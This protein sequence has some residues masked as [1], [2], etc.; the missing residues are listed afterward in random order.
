MQR[1]LYQFN[2]RQ[3]AMIEAYYWVKLFRFGSI[4]N[5]YMKDDNKI[6]WF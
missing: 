3:N 6:V 1:K 2:N 4:F 5:L